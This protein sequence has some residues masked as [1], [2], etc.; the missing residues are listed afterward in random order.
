M[1]KKLFV[2]LTVLLTAIPS[3]LATDRMYIS[4]FTIKVGE[5]KTVTVDLKND[6]AY[7]GFQ[8]DLYL[9]SGLSIAKKTNGKYNVSLN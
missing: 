9:P 2:L 5:T 1:I 6:T 4:D 3:L 7:T 8:L